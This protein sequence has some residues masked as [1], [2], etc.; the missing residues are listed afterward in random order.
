MTNQGITNAEIA[1]LLDKIAALLV[2][3]DANPFLVRSYWDA[4]RGCTTRTRREAEEGSPK[5]PAQPDVSTLL[6]VVGN[7][8]G[9]RMPVSSAR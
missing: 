7:T 8:A 4:Q 9:K 2:I 5:P 6:D 3:K 1:S